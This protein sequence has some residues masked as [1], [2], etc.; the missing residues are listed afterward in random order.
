MIDSGAG[1]SLI[2]KGIIEKLGIQK[3]QPPDKDLRDVSG[4]AIDI[5]GKTKLPVRI[6]GDNG[7][8]LEVNTDFFV[9]NSAN[10][11]CVLLGRNFMHSFG[12]TTFDFESNNIQ[13]GKTWCKGSR[14]SE[15][16]VKLVGDVTIPANS[17]KM[18]PVRCKGGNG[19][20]RGDFFPIKMMTDCAGVYTAKARVVP[21]SSGKFY[22]PVL[23]TSDVDV[24]LKSRQYLGKIHP[25]FEV[26]AVIND[27]ADHTKHADLEKVIIGSNVPEVEKKRI[28]EV[29]SR[30]ES[31]FAVNTKKPSLVSNATHKIVTQESQPIFKKPYPIPYAQ[32]DSVDTQVQEMLR[33][34]IIRPSTSPWNSPVILVKKKDHSLRFVC[35]FRGLN[36]ITV[37]DTYPLP[38]ISELI[39]KMDGT[40]LWTTL[41]AAS[42]YWSIPLE[43]SD[44]KKTAFSVPRGKFEFNVT[45]YGL[46]NAAASYQR[47]IDINL[48]GLSTSRILAYLDDIAL[49]SRTYDEHLQQLSE[50]LDCLSK[51]GISL[52]L[53][54]CRF[55]MEKVD[56]LGYHLSRDGVKPQERLTQAIE[57]FPRPTSKKEV[58]RF[59]GLCNYYR[60]FIPMFAEIANPLNQL[61][62]IKVPFN[63]DEK[64]ENAFM[65][66]KDRLCSYPILQFPK[67]GEKFE[68]EVDGSDT[69]VGGVL[70]QPNRSGKCLP[71]AYFSNSLNA[72]QQKWSAHTKEAYALVLALR[73]WR[74]YLAGITFTIRT[75]NNPLVRLRN[76]KDPRGKFS[77]WLT[78]LEEY[79]FDIE[80]KPGKSNVVPDVLSRVKNDRGDEPA[81]DFDEKIYSMFTD[82][83]NFK[84]QLKQEQDND[85]VINDAKQKVENNVEIQVGR[86][87]HIKKQLRIEDDLLT[88]NGRPIVPPKLRKF[89][90]TE[91]HKHSH[92][93]REKLYTLVQNKFYWPNLFRYIQNHLKMCDVCQKCKPSNRPPKAPL[94]PIV[95]PEYPMQFITIDI[96]YMVKDDM[97]HKYML[98]VGDLFS[99]YIDAIPL[100]DQTA[101]SISK[102]LYDKW[103]LTHGCP[104]YLLSDQGSNVDGNVIRDVCTILNIEKRRASS[105]HSQ[106]NGFAERSIRNVK[107][108]LRLNLH[109]GKLPQKEWSNKLKEMVFALNTTVSNATK[110][111]PY[112]VVFGREAVTPVDV[113][114]GCVRENEDSIST[115]DYT[116][117]LKIRLKDMYDT[118]KDN[119]NVSRAKMKANYDANTR[120][121]TYAVG[122]KVWLTK[123]HFKP[124]QSAKLAPRR[125]GPWSVTA[126]LPGGVTYGISLDGTNKSLVVHHNRLTPVYTD[127][128]NSD[129]SSEDEDLDDNNDDV[130]STGAAESSE[131]EEDIDIENPAQHRYPRRNRVPRQIEGAIPWD[132]IE[133]EPT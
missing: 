91:M 120:V 41:D 61:T 34:N 27:S 70:L 73:H 79:S 129:D 37:K 125:T 132:A 115:N 80:H 25:C 114:L 67:I 87:R 111:V 21:N 23:N 53:S 14:I 31:V 122:D 104:K 83:E 36:D 26:M 56:F 124:G 16:R 72:T 82:G 58:K 4:N 92:F 127:N 32:T 39:D 84:S 63:W 113:K 13:L 11:N 64:H 88:K 59:L 76:T 47:M 3:L 19:L 110:K 55:A 128:D 107:E 30:Y 48:S 108:I 8:N 74:V 12:S 28:L 121:N 69:A 51:C 7:E 123:K 45:P 52:N 119:L 2:T 57:T 42:A 77:R 81:D 50:V 97:G 43:E 68:V 71:V 103:M 86:L 40:I 17:E 85:P 131:E 112:E 66:L 5:I 99:K 118:V 93:G 109:E 60:D 20:T 95:D 106:G 6:I 65:E 44:K 22:I 18:V 98:L 33:N 133:L 94:V 38:R 105:Y 54:K 49:F 78:E 126:I 102:A 101:E 130:Q 89:V 10:T 15:S 1:C 100:C 35:D 9:S 29:L 46:C 24:T 117:E 90:V 75:D 62:S 116:D 96:A